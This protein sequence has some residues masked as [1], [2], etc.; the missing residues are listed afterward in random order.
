VP[1]RFVRN[2]KVEVAPMKDE[3]VLFN[4]SNNK[5]CVLN[6]TAA[7]I[8]QSLARPQSAHELALA[9]TGNFANV[10]LEQAEQD[11]QRALAELQR[12]ECIVY[13]E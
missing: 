10:G 3:T 9:I 1:D 6:A 2:A 7:Y 5:F 8:W 11:V 12:V 13:P 4:P